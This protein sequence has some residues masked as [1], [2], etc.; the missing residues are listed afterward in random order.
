MLGNFDFSDSTTTP[1]I[2][3]YDNRI[4]SVKTSEGVY[5]N[6]LTNPVIPYPFR[7]NNSDVQYVNS[8]ALMSKINELMGT[9]DYIGQFIS[10]DVFMEDG[11]VCG[12]TSQLNFLC[13]IIMGSPVEVHDEEI[14]YKPIKKVSF[15]YYSPVTGQ[16]ISHPEMLEI[17]NKAQME[18]GGKFNAV[19]DYFYKIDY[20]LQPSLEKALMG[21]Y[22]REIWNKFDMICVGEK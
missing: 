13:R 17:V 1:V 20:D 10:H 3:H 22:P 12:L 2:E 15:D 8:S 6:G 18:T 9:G 5:V 21:L 7:K 11:K 4:F 14:I 16:V 19:M